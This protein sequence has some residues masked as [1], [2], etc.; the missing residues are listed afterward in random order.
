MEDR[1]HGLPADPAKTERMRFEGLADP[2]NFFENIVEGGGSLLAMA[3]V[4]RGQSVTSPEELATITC[5]VM[6]LTGDQDCE[7]ESHRKSH[8]IHDACD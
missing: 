3:N 1:A 7:S 8:C 2:E 6:C 5:P 4:Q